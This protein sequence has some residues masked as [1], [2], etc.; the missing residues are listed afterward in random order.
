MCVIGFIKNEKNG[1][2]KERHIYGYR[3]NLRQR[4]ADYLRQPLRYEN[5]TLPKYNTKKAV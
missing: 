4:G 2:N 1:K 3:L 5:D